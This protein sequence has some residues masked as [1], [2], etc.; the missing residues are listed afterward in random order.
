MALFLFTKNILEGKPIPVFNHGKHTRD[1]TFIDDIAEGV[2]RTSDKIAEPDSAWRAD[3][4]DP[5]TSNAPFRLYNIG[6]NSPVKLEAYIEAIEQVLDRKAEKELLP[7]QKG[8]VPDTY[9][10]VSE[11]AAAV[12]TGPRPPLPPALPASFSGIGNIM[13]CDG[14]CGEGSHM[15]G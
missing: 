9:A 13:G 3:A 8:D 7:L 10:D 4:P 5:A 6:N 14:V 12:I 15:A 11:L 1:F 2:I